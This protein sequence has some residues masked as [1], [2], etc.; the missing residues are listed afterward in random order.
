MIKTDFAGNIIWQYFPSDQ[1][2]AYSIVKMI[3]T[4]DN[5]FLITFITDSI[6]LKIIKVSNSGQLIWSNAIPGV[7]NQ[8]NLIFERQDSYEFLCNQDNNFK[9]FRINKDGT[10]LQL[11]KILNSRFEN[12]IDGIKCSDNGYLISGVAYWNTNDNNNIVKYDFNWNSVWVKDFGGIVGEGISKVIETENDYYALG[13]NFSNEKDIFG[14][15]DLGSDFV[16]MRLDKSTGKKI[17]L[18]CAGGSNDD[19]FNYNFKQ[20]RQLG[21][22]G[23]IFVDSDGAILFGGQTYSSDN[24]VINSYNSNAYPNNPDAWL[25]KLSPELSNEKKILGIKPLSQCIGNKIKLF[26]TPNLINIGDN[27]QIQ[28]SNI[29]GNFE[30]PIIVSPTNIWKDS[31]ELEI[32]TSINNGGFGYKFKII[33]SIN[34]YTSLESGAYSINTIPSAKIIGSYEI[35]QGDLVKLKVNLKGGGPFNTF[36]SPGNIIHNNFNTENF[37]EEIKPLKSDYFKISSI[38]NICGSGIL[39][40]STFVKFKYCEKRTPSTCSYS[41]R[42]NQC[43]ISDLNNNLLINNQQQSCHND[44]NYNYNKYTTNSLFKPGNTYKIKTIRTEYPFL[45]YYNGYFVK[46]WIDKNKDNTFLEDEV[47]FLKYLKT[48]VVADSSTFEIPMSAQNGLTRIRIK[49]YLAKP[50]LVGFPCPENA[51]ETEVEDYIVNIAPLE[52]FTVNSLNLPSIICAG[53]EISFDF[54]STGTLTPQNHF[55]LKISDKEGNYFNTTEIQCIGNESP[56]RAIIP[57]ELSESSNYIFKLGIS[58]MAS[59]SVISKINLK[60]RP[61]AKFLTTD[62][63]INTN[64]DMTYELKFSGGNP[65]VFKMSDSNDSLISHSDNYINYTQSITSDSTFSIRTVSNF[66]GTEEINESIKYVVRSNI[67]K[68]NGNNN[69]GINSFVLKK[70]NNEVIIENINSGINFRAYSWYKALNRIK[71]NEAVN[72]TLIPYENNVTGLHLAIWIDINNDSLFTEDE[73]IYNTTDP[74]FNLQPIIGNFQFPDLE[75][76]RIMR[77]RTRNSYWGPIFSSCEAEFCE[78]EDYILNFIKPCEESKYLSG[79]AMKNVTTEANKYILSSQ[80]ISPNNTAIYRS[81]QSI[82]LEPGFGSDKGSI[83]YTD[84]TGCK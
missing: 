15:K 43:I 82:F 30:N 59:S 53:S 34:G 64:S 38:T 71:S 81:S 18:K 27:I 84:L 49:I 9:V 21:Y 22:N 77:I 36:L 25:V 40:D 11:Y 52:N 31:L 5:G 14:K 83:F 79:N 56:I 24:D 35:N 29:Y 13:Y 78:T 72:F 44:N 10:N 3:Q 46:A 63:I 58:N 6:N 2:F 55:V 62:E 16:I 7:S 70:N 23:S 45:N 17:W 41:M 32:P 74:S 37:L 19:G 76:L 20:Y 28:I 54:Q 47:L 48:S 50:S 66:C 69:Q 42:L 73:R 33:N 4:A 80:K 26:A 51:D 57:V 60:K 8:S 12:I 68:A 1:I 39:D 61:N 75:G 67:C 65:Y